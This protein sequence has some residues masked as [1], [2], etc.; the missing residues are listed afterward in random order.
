MHNKGGLISWKLKQDNSRGIIYAEV[1]CSITKKWY[2]E[3]MG[4]AGGS[5]YAHQKL[6]GI[7]DSLKRRF[8]LDTPLYRELEAS[9][10]KGVK[11]GIKR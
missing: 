1:Y 8:R 4:G 2:K 9:K 6:F 10:N 7:E 5:I 11:Y 3:T